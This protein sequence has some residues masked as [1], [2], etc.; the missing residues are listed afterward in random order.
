[1]RFSR[2]HFLIGGASWLVLAASGAAAQTACAELPG[3]DF[4][5]LDIVSADLVAATDAHPERCEV[6]AEIPAQSNDEW[7]RP[8]TFRTI[9]PSEWNGNSIQFGGGGYNGQLTEQDG[10]RWQTAEAADQFPFAGYATFQGDSGHSVDDLPYDNNVDPRRASFAPYDEALTRY[11]YKALL[12][13]FQAGMQIIEAHYGTAPEFSYF[14]GFSN[15]GREA[16]QVAQRYPQNYDGIL[17]GDPVLNLTGLS[18]LHLEKSK[19][20]FENDGEAWV[21]PEKGALVTNEIYEQCDAIDGLA[22]DMIADYRMC[23][24]DLSPLLCAG[25]ETMECLT[26]AQLDAVNAIH[27]PSTLEVELANGV[28]GHSGYPWGNVRW[29]GVFAGARPV[30]STP[31]PNQ[32]G[33]NDSYLYSLGEG[34]ARFFI[35]ENAEENPLQFDQNDP[36]WS[37]RTAEVSA[38]IDATDPDLSDFADAGGKIIFYAGGASEVPPAEFVTYWDRMAATMGSDT[39]DEFARFYVFPSLHHSGAGREGIPNS[40]DLLT[41]IENWVTE[42]EAPGVLT[43]INA[44]SGVS[45]PLCVFPAYARYDGEGD[46]SEATSFD[47]VTE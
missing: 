45:R 28:M 20:F 12:E 17:A 31:A 2:I 36:K 22:D 38:I 43:N 23:E 27:A 39:V 13:T 11:G 18:L 35:A 8:I 30:P 5:R 24:P 25:E 33:V 3:A 41:A 47:C 34:F 32:G 6:L 29:Q 10:P 4:E 46:E 26:A 40:A 16:L 42:G 9:L 21:P 15:G 1:M 44:D 19:N 37:D 14:F 7:T